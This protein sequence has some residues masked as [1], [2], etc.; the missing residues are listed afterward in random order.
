MHDTSYKVGSVAYVVSNKK[1]QVFPVRVIEQVIRKTLDGQHI[2][3]R[4]SVASSKFSSES[5]DDLDVIDLHRINGQVYDTL[6][7]VREALREQAHR[8]IEDVLQQADD[9][10]NMCFPDIDSAYK[11]RPI[12]PDKNLSSSPSN[13]ESH[14]KSVPVTMPDGSRANVT[15]PVVQ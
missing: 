14:K 4:V 10:R 9:L 3:Y 6:E 2:T 15:L 5:A 12:D 7:V 13:G 8:A 11:T 1:R